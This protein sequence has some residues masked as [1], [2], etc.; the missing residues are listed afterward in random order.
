MQQ[1]A[2]TGRSFADQEL[3]MR[4]PDGRSIQILGNAVPLFDEEGKPRGAVG[5]FL[6]VTERK[7]TEEELRLATERFR[8]SLRNAPDH[9]F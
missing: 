2:A 3:E 9:G 6:D 1:A 7:R 8:I 4:Y 5:A